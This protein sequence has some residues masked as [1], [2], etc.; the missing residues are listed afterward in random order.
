[1]AN[2]FSISKFFEK[3]RNHT[4]MESNQAIEMIDL[5]KKR[6]KS[7]D[8][9][10][11]L[12]R[13]NN[14]LSQDLSTIAADFH[15]QLQLWHTN[16]LKF[17]AL[18]QQEKSLQE[19][20]QQKRELIQLL[21]NQKESEEE[22]TKALYRYTLNQRKKYKKNQLD[23]LLY[24]AWLLEQLYLENGKI[25][26]AK[27]I[28]DEADILR[29]SAFNP[30]TSNKFL[31]NT[32]LPGSRFIQSLGLE[33]TFIHD[34]FKF[35]GINRTFLEDLIA[36]E[37]NIGKT[38]L[39]RLNLCLARVSIENLLALGE[40]NDWLKFIPTLDGNPLNL[41]QL[42]K[43]IKKTKSTGN[44]LSIVLF[45]ARFFVT[46]TIIAMECMEASSVDKDIRFWNLFWEKMGNL[47][48]DA[49]WTLFNL[50]TNYADVLNIPDPIANTL[51][52][53]AL[54][55]DVIWTLR[56]WYSNYQ[57]FENSK[58]QYLKEL[59]LLDKDSQEYAMTMESLK[60]LIIK[61][62]VTN[63]TNL[64]ATIAAVALA[65]ASLLPLLLAPT[66]TNPV[67]SIP[68]LTVVCDFVSNVAVGIYQT[69]SR[70]STFMEKK[71]QL[72]W[73][74]TNLVLNN[75]KLVEQTWKATDVLDD[76]VH[77]QQRKYFTMEY[78]FARNRLIFDL[79]VCIIMPAVLMSL[80]AV[81]FPLGAAA[82]TIFFVLVKFVLEPW[83][84]KRQ[85]KDLDNKKDEFMKEQD[86][87]D[88]DGF[89]GL[90]RWW[91]HDKPADDLQDASEENDEQ[92]VLLNN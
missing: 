51:L 35:L 21:N 70:F 45:A 20:K 76:L 13:E 41:E 39:W 9:I 61:W 11:F 5:Q 62:E 28:R 19:K 40:K 12:R 42:T 47:V 7:P 54:L 49:F 10:Q 31:A 79:A 80:S 52:C 6:Y 57:A 18:K 59:S 75:G 29:K 86:A 16:P 25:D 8:E 37:G 82:P 63:T 77:T 50:L 92:T 38:N 73:L 87:L 90:S 17:S 33:G 4:S 83:W 78:E 84:D 66:L 14:A 36:L 85:Q 56:G 64:Y 81:C 68:I 60:Q 89:L 46:L 58:A 24:T 22:Q 88:R 3:K 26:K 74:D 72:A 23:Y 27:N 44:A 55:G 67:I 53:F 30:D 32:P 91:T 48:N 43:D 65:M 1:M 69:I 15:V 71:E 34:I 2:T